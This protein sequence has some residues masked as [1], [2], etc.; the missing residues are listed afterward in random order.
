M[1]VQRSKMMNWLK[2]SLQKLWEGMLKHLGTLLVAFLVS[3][4]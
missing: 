3:G 2:E 4:G 1:S